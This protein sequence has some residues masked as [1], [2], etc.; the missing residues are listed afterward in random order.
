MLAS[1]S[2]Y[3]LAPNTWRILVGAN[4]PNF[5][6]IMFSVMRTCLYVLPLCISN[7]SPTKLGRIVHDRAFVRIGIFFSRACFI[8]R[9]TIYGTFQADLFSNTGESLIS[10]HP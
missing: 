6:P 9:E 4:S 5:M 2:I 7:I 3:F 10:A 8:G 1:I